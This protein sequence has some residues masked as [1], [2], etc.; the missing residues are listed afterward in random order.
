MLTDVSEQ[1]TTERMLR[2]VEAKY[3]TLVEQ[4][5]FGVALMLLDPLKIL[6]ANEALCRILGCSLEQLLDIEGK[7]LLTWVHPEERS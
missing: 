4:A 2:D 7:Q 5:P 3:R 1:K 6:V